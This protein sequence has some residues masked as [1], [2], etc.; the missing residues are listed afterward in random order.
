MYIHIMIVII[1]LATIALWFGA[2]YKDAQK[3]EDRYSLSA[4]LL[5]SWIIADGLF[6]V[7]FFVLRAA[8]IFDITIERLFFAMII[9]SL[10]VGLL[11]GTV[12][13]ETNITIEIAM[14][15]FS[16]VCL[17]SMIR[18][19]FTAVTPDFISPWFAF[20]SGYLFPFLIFIFSKNF[21]V[22]EKDVMLIFH[23]LFYF[24]LYLSI[25]ALLEF[26]NLRQFIFPQYINDPTIG[27]HIDRARGTFLNAAFNGVGI[28][29]GFICGVHLLQKKTGFA[30]VFYQLALLAFFPA[31]F[32]TLTRSVYVG[33]VI[34]LFIFLGWYKTS[35]SKWKLIALPLV[36]VMM[37][38]IA[39]SPRLFSKERREGGVLQKEEVDIRFALLRRSYFFFAK[40][41]IA[42]IGLAQFTPSSIR[43]YTG[44]VSFIEEEAPAT[45]Q[46]NHLLG[47]A[48]E[49][50]IP[51][52]LSYL[53][54]LFLILW[55]LKLVAGKLPA[56]GII[57]NNLP[58]VIFAVWGVYLNNN[59]FTEP[60]S[61]IFINAIPFL[62]AGLADGLYTRYLETGLLSPSP[63]RVSP[64]SLRIIKNHV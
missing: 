34:T 14:G 64:S 15:I 32:F 39:N 37:I 63:I 42:G 35:F 56:T 5:A 21:I 29:I 3:V 19:G 30:Q 44:R 41:P 7:H 13:F 4:I 51:G 2:G 38:G 28:L 47:V 27:I 18:Y 8:G 36:I 6:G 40:H 60:S 24:G 25:V 10:A 55:R 50:G 11:K 43:S 45:L 49:L 17:I 12:R 9:F 1:A 48:T 22:R 23:V 53:A 54:M 52:L 61:N 58:I 46:H 33:L 31:V 62:F 26:T 20:I 59:L 16:L 57:G